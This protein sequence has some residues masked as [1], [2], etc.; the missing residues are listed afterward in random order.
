[1]SEKQKKGFALP[2]NRKH[3]NKGGRPKGSRNRNSLARAQRKVDDSAPD[4]INFYHAVLM[5]DVETLKN[6]YGFTE[7]EIRT[8]SAKMR[9][10]AAKELIKSATDEMKAIGGEKADKEYEKDEEEVVQAKESEN[11]KVVP[12]TFKRDEIED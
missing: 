8:L 5:G 1:M 3:I 11:S 6:K 2:E 7:E 4:A 9:M 10:D 12:F